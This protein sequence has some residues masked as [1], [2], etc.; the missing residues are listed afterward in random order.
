MKHLLSVLFIVLGAFSANART[1]VVC[2]SD[3]QLTLKLEGVY[4]SPVIITN[5]LI[6]NNTAPN[7]QSEALINYV[8]ETPESI[9]AQFVNLET[10]SAFDFELG[11]ESLN[12]KTFTLF[13]HELGS[14]GSPSQS[15][16]FLCETE[17]TF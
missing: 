2:Q 13:V 8:N 6:G 7:T 17:F 4:T 15:H 10:A 9:V 11:K 12:F 3:T 16:Q 14:P 5:I 1:N